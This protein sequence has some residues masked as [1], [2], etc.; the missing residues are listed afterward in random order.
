MRFV[1]SFFALTLPAAV[2]KTNRDDWMK[3]QS[4]VSSEAYWIARREL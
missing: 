3:Q 1:L 2:L 4:G